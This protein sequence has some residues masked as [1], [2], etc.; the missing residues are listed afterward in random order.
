MRFK[1]FA[2]NT[3]LQKTELIIKKTFAPERRE[4]Q[5]KIIDIARQ[6]EMGK[7]DAQAQQ[8]ELLDI[9]DNEKKTLA[10]DPDLKVS[11]EGNIKII[12]NALKKLGV[13]EQDLKITQRTGN[14]VKA[15]DGVEIDLDQVDVEVDPATKKTKIKPKGTTP[16]QQ[17][18]K[19]TIKPGQTVELS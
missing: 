4:V 13:T 6:I 7:G 14:K 12:N 9:L 19:D 16:G 8:A 11:V 5:E 17:N 15:G 2:E 3:A 18:P 1:Q 10:A